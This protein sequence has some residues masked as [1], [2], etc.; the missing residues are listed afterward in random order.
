[1]ATQNRCIVL[2]IF[3]I[4]LCVMAF[5]LIIYMSLLSNDNALM[6]DHLAMEQWAND[7]QQQDTNIPLGAI[8]KP[9]P[10]TNWGTRYLPLRVWCCI[11]TIYTPY[12]MS[13]IQ[14][15][16]GKHCDNLLFFIGEHSNE[17]V[18]SSLS[19]NIIKLNLSNTKYRSKYLIKPNVWEKTWK[20]QKFLYDHHLSDF[21]WI[22]SADND[23]WFS[24]HNFKWFAQYLDPNLPW[25]LGDTI[26]HQWKHKNI[27]FNAGGVFGLSRSAIE[28]LGKIY[29][30][31]E[32]LYSNKINKDVDSLSLCNDHPAWDDDVLLAGC[33][34]TV[35]VF[36]V[37]ML[38][39]QYK[40]RWS[41]FSH[42]HWPL[43]QFGN[44]WYFDNRFENISM[45]ADSLSSR[46][47]AFHGYKDHK[48]N[49]P[50]YAF[51]YL[52]QKYKQS[53]SE[54]SRAVPAKPTT[55]LFSTN[56]TAFDQYFNVDRP[57]KHQKIWKGV[58]NLW[59]YSDRY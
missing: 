28:K 46:M 39:D 51:S 18:P 4:T 56:W 22:I 34:K 13:M 43:L 45:G 35:G 54:M 24:T 52:D 3:V 40:T 32:F 33:L 23:G 7:A 2:I 16:W 21:D 26:L 41:C 48:T 50:R 30:T 49:K 19:P 47:I 9:I 8:G 20:L 37:N 10:V 53:E 58:D 14:E 11:K 27:V 59:N 55:F 15:T 38:D 17:V 1:M 42:T 31:K 5:Q 36:P 25:Y 12:V 6:F 44:M 29:S 57:P